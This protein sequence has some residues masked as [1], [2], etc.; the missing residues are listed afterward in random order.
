[1]DMDPD[2][3]DPKKHVDPDPDSDPQHWFVHGFYSISGTTRLIKITKTRD[4]PV[5]PSNDFSVF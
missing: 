2:P 3:G 5:N 1:M 4:N